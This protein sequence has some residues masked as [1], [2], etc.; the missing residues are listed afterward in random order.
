MPF[1]YRLYLWLG[2]LRRRVRAPV[3]L[4]TRALVVRDGMVLLVKLT[5]SRGW[6]LPG[7]G[8]DRGESIYAGMVR[9]LREECGIDTLEAR[10]FGLHLNR[11]DGRLDH[12]ATY[13]VQR[14]SGEPR[15]ADP[16][17]IAEAKFFLPTDLPADLWPGH[18]RR[19]DE[20]FSGAPPSVD[21]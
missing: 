16:R 18:R 1:F 12:V 21:W 7:G 20:F 15:A 6:Y 14:Y 10:L 2:R 3:T 8:V 9:E 11:R 13:V 5:Y 19:I 4:G 17:E